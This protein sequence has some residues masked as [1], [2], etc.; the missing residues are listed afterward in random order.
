MLHKRTNNRIHAHRWEY[1]L[2]NNRSHAI[3]WVSPLCQFRQRHA[4]NPCKSFA[5]HISLEKQESALL[6]CLRTC[7][8]QSVEAS[9]ICAP[10]RG[11]SDYNTTRSKAMFFHLVPK[12]EC[13]D[14]VRVVNEVF[15][16]TDAD[17]SVHWFRLAVWQHALMC[18][19]SQ[20]VVELLSCLL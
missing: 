11:R 6:L 9:V 15:S 20:D 5:M 1:P 18:C 12:P 13:L 7:Q 4:N 14:V 10:V 19:L 2:S 16:D 17:K 3:P 8:T